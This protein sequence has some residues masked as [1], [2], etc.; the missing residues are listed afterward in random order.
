MRSFHNSIII[1]F[2]GKSVK[3]SASKILL[4]ATAFFAI[5]QFAK[6]LAL[7]F[8]TTPISVIG[9][10]FKIQIYQNTGIA[11]SI[12]MPQ[13]VIIALTYILL[14]GG[15]YFAYKDLN[16]ENHWTQ[17]LL[18]VIAGGAAGNLYNRMT[19]G[20]VVDFIAIANYPVFNVAD[21]GIAVGLFCLVIFYDTLRSEAKERSHQHAKR[22]P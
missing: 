14:A 3:K 21:I 17:L 18:G 8:A 2:V 12:N 4:I 1:L 7:E 22:E 11:F 6:W 10:F 9:D 16:L 5:D 15:I 20:S 19:M 13:I